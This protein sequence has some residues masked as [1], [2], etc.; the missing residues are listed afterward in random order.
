MNIPSILSRTWDKIEGM[1][2]NTPYLVIAALVAA[3]LLVQN[4]SSTPQLTPTAVAEI[5]TALPA[6]D[7]PIPTVA[8]SSYEPCGY[9]WAY[10]N[11]EELGAMFDEGMRDMHPAT[12][13]NVSFYGE[14][15]VYADGTSTFSALET[16]FFVRIPVE[17]LTNEDVLGEWISLTLQLVLELPTDMLQG[18]Y[19]FVEFWFEK[20]ASEQ[21]TMRVPIQEYMDGT[22]GIS[23]ATLFRM[24][25]KEP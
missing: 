21:L 9:Q 4:L 3:G 8:T 24:F 10:H 22:H 19:G 7:T 20:S 17:E 18:K 2:K 25:Y 16:D 1:K 5:Q 23:G 12:S 13:G 11:A 15:C 6:T 14:D